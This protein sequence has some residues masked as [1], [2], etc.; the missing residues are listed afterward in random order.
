MEITEALLDA[1]RS[2]RGGWSRQQVELLGVEW[3]LRQGWKRAVIGKTVS[4]D[5][6]EEFIRMAGERPASKG[7]KR[8]GPGNWCGGSKPVDIHLYVLELVDGCFYVGLTADIKSRLKQH[9]EGKGAVWTALHRPIRVLHTVCTGTRDAREAEQMENEA[10]I[11][12]MMRYGVEK[13]RGGHYCSIELE[14]VEALLRTRGIWNGIKRAVLD[15]QLIRTDASWSEALD[16]FAEK[17][18]SYY[19]AGA[20]ADQLDDVFGACYRL[21]RYRYWHEDFAPG[22]SWHFWNT[23]GVLPVILSFKHGRPIGSRVSSPYEVLANALM[24][25]KNGEHPLRRL[26][27]LAWRAFLPPA[28]ENQSAAV[29]RHMTYLDDVGDVD[30]QY[31]PFVSVLFPEMRSYLRG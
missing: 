19:E 22:L 25:G 5:V 7:E 31:D 17:A 9:I 1:G 21:T 2:E 28:T 20:P 16:S 29:E 27:L 23:K 6:A 26:F 14:P 8:F 4:D 15:R 13:V 11:T 12:L 30:R 10:T 18:L 24:R 3:P